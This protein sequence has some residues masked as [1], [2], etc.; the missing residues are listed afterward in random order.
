MGDDAQP[1]LAVKA[2]LDKG[3]IGA[4]SCSPVLTMTSL[5]WPART[6]AKF[7][8]IQAGTCSSI[9]FLHDSGHRL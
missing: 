1:A 4:V 6:L 2:G 5:S 7:L 8:P 9:D 3:S